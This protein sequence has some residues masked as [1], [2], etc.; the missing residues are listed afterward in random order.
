MSEHQEISVKVNAW[1]DEGVADLVTALSEFDARLVTLES[2]QGGNGGDAF[3]YFRLGDW[4]EC[5]Q[6]LF[7]KL[8]PA[9]DP[10]LRAA[11]SIRVQAYD[12]DTA[13]GSI[14]IDPAA[15]P[16]MVRCISRLAST[17]RARVLVTRNAHCEAVA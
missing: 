4:K 13:I 9:M 6:F 5:G 7:G 14:M 2:C 8:L 17:V 15:V 16:S 3:V 12:A 11:T 10:D 1:V